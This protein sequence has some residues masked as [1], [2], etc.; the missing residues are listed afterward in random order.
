MNE[1]GI[2]KI[3]VDYI[4][5]IVTGNESKPCYQIK[6]REVGNDDYNIGFGSYDLNNVLKWKR[7]EFKVVPKKFEKETKQEVTNEELL[8]HLKEIECAQGVLVAGLETIFLLMKSRNEELKLNNNELEM[9]KL[10]SVAMNACIDHLSDISGMNEKVKEIKT[11]ITE[12]ILDD[13]WKFFR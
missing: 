9:I 10:G 5:V 8:Y 4:E 11:S 6:Y 2:N 7:E 1:N 13:M 12:N 3:A